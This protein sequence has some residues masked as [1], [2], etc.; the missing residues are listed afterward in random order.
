MVGHDRRRTITALAVE[1]G[2]L[3]LPAVPAVASVFPPW[4]VAES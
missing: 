2:P 1:S 4:R 3:F